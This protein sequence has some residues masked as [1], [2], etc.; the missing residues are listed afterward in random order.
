M[1]PCFKLPET[2]LCSSAVAGKSTF[3]KAE[4]SCE[5]AK[6]HYMFAML[7]ISERQC[8][9]LYVALSRLAEQRVLKLPRLS[10]IPFEPLQPWREPDDP[11][12]LGKGSCLSKCAS[13]YRHSHIGNSQIRIQYS[14]HLT[15]QIVLSS[16]FKW[17]LVS[18]W[19]SQASRGRLRLKVRRATQRTL[20]WLSMWLSAAT[21]ALLLH[22]S[23]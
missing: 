23:W 19:R 18:E 8:W 5:E 9:T 21:E 14:R 13:A 22:S 1:F 12:C 10:K 7:S 2:A 3:G 4:A 11:L 17:Y 16:P 15:Y 6:K 20:S